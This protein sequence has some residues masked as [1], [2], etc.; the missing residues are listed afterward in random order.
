MSTRHALLAPLALL[1]L[2]AASATRG[3]AQAFTGT[4]D[5]TL[6]SLPPAP[7]PARCGA[8]PP[9]L[10]I[11]FGTAPGTSTFGAF[12][13]TSSTCV[14]RNTGSFFNGLFTFD[15]GGGRTLFGTYTGQI[16]L[17]LP[18]PVGVVTAISE[19]LTILG[20]TGAFAGAGG[21]I[22]AVGSETINAD[23]TYRLRLGMT[24]AV[25]TV[26]EP[27][28]V[29]LLAGG[30]VATGMFARRRRASSLRA[31]ASLEA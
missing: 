26:P 13:Y 4:I 16:A 7:D 12:T 8:T 6:P 5:A 3:H 19:S 17:P 2:G 27:A 24:G 14:D 23:N 18:P 22:A 15:F 9:N 10:R 28:T 29:L 1:V 21:T 11:D 30:L 31:G 25:T 20:G